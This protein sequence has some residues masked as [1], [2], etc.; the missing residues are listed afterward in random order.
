MLWC[1]KYY[2]SENTMVHPE[3]AF[4]RN[5]Q[6]SIAG[7]TSCPPL[8]SFH[9]EGTTHFSFTAW[10]KQGCINPNVMLQSIFIYHFLIDDD[11]LG[12]SSQGKD[13]GTQYALEV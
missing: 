5:V 6:F 7:M 12:R 3:N 13:S 8:D 11:N 2:E 9:Q 4:N 10:P 1:L